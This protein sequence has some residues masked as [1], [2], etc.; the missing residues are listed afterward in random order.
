MGAHVPLL[1]NNNIMANLRPKDL[2]KLGFTDNITRSL[3]TTIVAK[4]YKH[5]SNGEISE[6]LTALK[7]DPGGYAAHPELGK[8]AQ[9][10]VSEERECTFK[11]FDLLTTSRT[12]KVY[13]AR[14]IEYSAKQQM[15]TAMSLPISVQGALMPDAHAGYGLPIGGVL[16]T[17]GAIVPYAVGV[18]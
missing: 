3:I 4:N 11:S 2:S 14:E 6:L 13:G 15:E 7:N 5:Q 10:M 1:H 16:A 18:D 9:S 8:I 17:A 12:L